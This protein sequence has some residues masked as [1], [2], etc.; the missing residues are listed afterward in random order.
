MS[1]SPPIQSLYNLAEEVDKI[2]K[3]RDAALA[4]VDELA[5]LIEDIFRYHCRTDDPE[6]QVT[7]AEACHCDICEPARYELARWKE[8]KHEKANS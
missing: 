1:I 2:I 8:A 6:S 5:V 4:K 7:K 3:E